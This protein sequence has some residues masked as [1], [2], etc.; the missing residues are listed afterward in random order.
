MSLT[1]RAATPGAGT[2]P[3]PASAAG[4]GRRLG[5]GPAATAPPAPRDPVRTAATGLSHQA[6]AL[7]VIAGCNAMIQLDDPIVN[8]ALPGMRAGLGLSAVSASWVLG[9]Y[10]L[11]FGALLLLGGRAGDILGRRRLFL[12]GVALFTVAA[13]LRALAPSGAVMIAVRALQGAGAALAAPSGLA[14]LLGTYAEG[15]ARRRAIGVCTAVGAC[16]TAGG[17]L[18]AGVLSFLGSWRWMLLLNVPIGVAVLLLGPR[19]LDETARNLGRFDL[20]GALLSAA[21]AT[22]VVY[23][24]ARA[25]DHP[26]GDATVAGPLSAGLVLLLVF[27]A[28]ERR[29][30]QP[31]VLPRLF[32]DR[33]R[34]LA[35]VAVL[36]VPGAL[37]G[38]YFFLSRFFQLHGWS[39]LTTAIALL[40]LP[41]AMAATAACAGT[42]ARFASPRRLMAVGAVTLTVEN[43]WLSRLEAGD[44]YATDVLPTLLLLGIGMALC[45]VPLTVLATSGLRGSEAG[46][47]CSVLNCLQALGGS[48]G[49]ALLVTA[50]SGQRTFT[51]TL[52]RGFTAGAVFGVVVLLAALAVRR[53]GSGRPRSG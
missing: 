35:Y 8:V 38:V 16:S 52:S 23:G 37:I 43:L 10:L 46:A 6:L 34:L 42:L 29:V 13:A 17:L 26:W 15:A 14:L 19:V 2:L 12:T 41:L 44:T 18:L 50:S 9:A 11:A 25:A 48:L 40:P 53:P 7:A 32:A 4:P 28:V 1:E 21:G 49:V 20:P 27:V 51:Q 5:P 39:P 30:E 24:L 3:G 31:I 33:N 47:A 45:V 36:A 22:G